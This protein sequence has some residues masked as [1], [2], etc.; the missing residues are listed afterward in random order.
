MLS[1]RSLRLA[2]VAYIMTLSALSLHALENK[3]T[4]KYEA[5]IVVFEK[6]DKKTPP[7]EGAILFIGASQFTRWKTMQE[8]LPEFNV[9]NRGFGGSQ[10]SDVLNFIERI[11]IPYKPKIIV[12][13]E[14]GN[15][16]HAGKSP[17]QIL[18]DFKT[19]VDKVRAK[20]PDVRIVFSGLTPSPARI[21][22]ADQQKKTNELL[23]AFATSGKNLAFIDLY[24]A[25]LGIDG[26]PKDECF[27]QDKLHHTPAGYKIRIELMKPHLGEPTKK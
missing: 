17:E 14:G 26:K 11:V 23:K 15:D 4:P 1:A 20:L 22:E 16:L 10:M 27:V 21:K 19:F 13:Q 5:T 7:P 18:A 2:L 3:T 25:Y 12:T 6:A 9:I 8:D 24:D